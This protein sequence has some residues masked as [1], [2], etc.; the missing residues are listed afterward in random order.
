MVYFTN[1]EFRSK[2][3]EWCP[4]LARLYDSVLLILTY[5]INGP[6]GLK[7]VQIKITSLSDQPICFRFIA[8]IPSI[9]VGPLHSDKATGKWKID[10]FIRL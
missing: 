6:Q 4:S 3:L 1:Q 5:L 10:P 7:L 8:H 2:V 9:H